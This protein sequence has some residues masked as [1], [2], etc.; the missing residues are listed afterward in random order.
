VASQTAGAPKVTDAL[1][2]ALSA[3]LLLRLATGRALSRQALGPLTALAVL[4]LVWLL[5]DAI[6]TGDPPAVLPL[7]WL[8]ALPYAYFLRHFAR[9]PDTRNALL[10][11]LFGG[12]LGNVAVLGLQVAGYGELAVSLGLAS[13]RFA[14]RW[15]KLGAEVEF[16]AGGM[17]GHP[18]ASA[19]IVA[20]GF[21]VVCGLIDEGRLRPRWIVAGL[22]LVSLSVVLTLTRS[23]MLVSAFV[24]L[25]WAFHRHE[26]FRQ[27][28]WRL[29]ALVLLGIAVASIGPPGGWERWTDQDNLSSNSGERLESTIES[30][31][32]ALH[33]PL[34][35]GEGYLP[36][37]IEATGIPATHNAWFFLALFAGLPLTAFVLFAVVRHAASL[38]V[39]RTTEGWVALQCMGIFMFEEYFRTSAVVLVAVWLVVTPPA[40]PLL[41]SVVRRR[42]TLR[43]PAARAV[44]S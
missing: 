4:V 17:W 41:A 25:A 26:S 31:R 38:L 12:A 36:L 8:L 27:R 18:N 14:E 19:G 35:L 30:L 6:T 40:A 33:H 20:L 43:V 1:G 7:R 28:A 9:D 39:R 10:F 5:R 42:G 3:V 13:A 44:P 23:A 29:A 32:I 34:G 11:G 22:V 2:V 24:F 15:A 21:P 37:L 16:R